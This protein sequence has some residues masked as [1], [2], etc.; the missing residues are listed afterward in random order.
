[1]YEAVKAVFANLSQYR[2]EHIFIDNASKDRTPVILRELAAAEQ[3]GEGDPQ[4]AEFRPRA[5]RLLRAPPGAWRCDHRAGV[6]LPGPARADPGIPRAGRPAKVVLGVKENGR[7]ARPLLRHS[8]PVLPHARAHRGH[9]ARAAVHRVRLLRPV[10]DRVAA[11]DRRSVSVFP[12]VDRRDRATTSRDPVPAADA[13]A[14]GHVAELLHAVR[15]RLPRHRESFE[16]AAAHGD[17]DRLRMRAIDCSSR[18]GTSRQSCCSGA[19]SR[20]E[21]RRS[22]SGSSS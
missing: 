9:R 14:R 22:S 2:Y 11:E 20:W 7:R 21:S 12:R 4:H 3:E 19:S 5:V 18:S 10:G 15:H 16:G 17:D 8:R 13:Q 1:M 6:R